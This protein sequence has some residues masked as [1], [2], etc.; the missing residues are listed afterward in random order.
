MAELS[1]AKKRLLDRLKVVEHATAPELAAEFG[2][3][4]TAVRQHLETLEAADMVE[5]VA[6]APAG[7]GR[8]PSAWKLT[9][10]AA[11]AFPDRHRDL[12][13]EL[14][15]SVRAQG[16]P[17]AIETL[18]SDRAAQQ[19]AAYRTEGDLRQRLEHLTASRSAEGY[20]AETVH[21]DDHTALFVEHHCPIATAAR[22]CGELCDSELQVIQRTLGPRVSVQRTQHLLAGDQRCAYAIAES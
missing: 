1:D 3:T 15:A 17:E 18:L 10:L 12:A 20:L 4:D 22:S 21:H 8:P 13:V 6:T 14:L 9:T 7:R 11:T 2:L 19:V 16:G 5:R